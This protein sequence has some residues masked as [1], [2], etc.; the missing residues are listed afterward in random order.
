MKKT[1]LSAF[2][3]A[4]IAPAIFAQDAPKPKIDISQ[5]P[6]EARAVEEVIVPVPSEIFG[7]LDKLGKPNWVAVQRPLKGVAKPFGDQP[8]NAFYLGTII[9]EGFIAVES[10]DATEVTNIGN[11]V[12]SLSRALGVQKAVTK[13]ANAIITA[14]TKGNWN[15]VRAEL[16]GALSVVKA[17]LMELDSEEL[18]NLVALGGWVRGTE[19]LSD[20][21]QKNYSKDGADLLHQ[22]LLVNHFIGTLQGLK[23]RGLKKHALVGKALKSLQSIQPLMSQGEGADIS[24]KSVKEIGDAAAGL[25]KDIQTK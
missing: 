4:L 9:A 13:R 15:E 12:L 7:V 6:R 24:P 3:L 1:A 16:D 18:A 14:A 17:A 5:L 23:G 22:P 11:S 25:V 8:H 19:A 2:A 21:V 20:V 10:G